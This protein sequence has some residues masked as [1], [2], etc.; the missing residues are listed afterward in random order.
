MPTSVWSW[1]TKLVYFSTQHLS[2]YLAEYPLRLPYG[3]L[4][5]NMAPG[6]FLSLFQVYCVSSRWRFGVLWAISNELI[7]RKSLTCIMYSCTYSFNRKELTAFLSGKMAPS[8]L[9]LGP[10]C[11]GITPKVRSCFNYGGIITHMFVLIKQLIDRVCS[12][13]WQLA[14]YEEAPGWFITPSEAAL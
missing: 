7:H 13:L 2:L 14:A 11:H 12:V 10:L 5:E 1:K 8:V 3:R 9:H 6:A 4:S